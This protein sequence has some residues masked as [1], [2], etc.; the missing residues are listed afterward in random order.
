MSEP[1]KSVV[2]RRGR[3]T[4]M[5]QNLKLADGLPL[6]VSCRFPVSLVWYGQIFADRLK[7]GDRR[8]RDGLAV[9]IEPA[10]LMI[11]SGKALEGEQFLARCPP[12]ADFYAIAGCPIAELLPA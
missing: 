4:A 7:H 3:L 10:A 1:V 6:E 8:L 5:R 9:D 12:I 11:D 2:T